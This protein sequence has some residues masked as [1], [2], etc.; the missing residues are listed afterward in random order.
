MRKPRRGGIKVVRNDKLL[1]EMAP[2]PAYRPAKS[3]AEIEA[4]SFQVAPESRSGL[5]ALIMLIAP[6]AM[7][8]RGG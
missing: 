7:A 5:S 8:A 4:G 6:E 2:E 1:N 3:I